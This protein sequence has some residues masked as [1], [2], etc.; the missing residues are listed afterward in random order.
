MRSYDPT[1]M[2]LDNFLYKYGYAAMQV[3]LGFHHL[4][5]AWSI[6]PLESINRICRWLE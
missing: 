3:C 4:R 5:L 1:E 6:I 2:Q